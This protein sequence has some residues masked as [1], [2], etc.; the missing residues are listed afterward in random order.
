VNTVCP[1]KRNTTTLTDV[2]SWAT[3]LQ[4]SKALSSD[5]AGDADGCTTVGNTRGESAD[6]AGLVLSGQSHLVVLTIDGNVLHMLLR[7]FLDG[8]LDSLHSSRFTHGLGGVVGV[9][10]GTV[11]V[12]GE[13]LGVERDFDTP[14]FGNA[15]EKEAGHPE[16]VTH[17]DT[18]ARADLEF[19]LRRHDLCVDSGDVHASVH[20]CSIVG[21]DEVT[22]KDLAGP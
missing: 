14:F 16:M 5:V 13:R 2:G 20:A 12:T 21:L 19:P 18:L 1:G 4:V 17:G 15:D 8:I 3:I 6:M 7:Q 9:A 22:C 10:P 11:P